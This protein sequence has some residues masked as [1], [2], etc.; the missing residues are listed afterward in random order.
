VGQ[1]QR[2]RQIGDLVGDREAD[3]RGD[4]DVGR[5]APMPVAEGSPCVTSQKSLLASS[6]ARSF[7]LISSPSPSSDVGNIVPIQSVASSAI[8]SWTART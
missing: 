1:E 7:A 3:D 5:D 2:R 8:S 6:A 4:A